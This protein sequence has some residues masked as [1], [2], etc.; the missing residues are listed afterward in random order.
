MPQG[1]RKKQPA[2]PNIKQKTKKKPMGLKK[3]SKF[4]YQSRTRSLTR[5]RKSRPH[6]RTCAPV[7]V[8]LC[9]THCALFNLL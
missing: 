5:S 6:I 3:G 1:A 7:D 4:Q 9:G 8:A 2:R